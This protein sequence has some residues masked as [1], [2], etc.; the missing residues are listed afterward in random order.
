M[1]VLIID[2][3][4]P[5]AD[6]L[7]RFLE[8]AGVKVDMVVKPRYAEAAKEACSVLRGIQKEEDAYTALVLDIN[9]KDHFI[10]GIMVYTKILTEG[11]RGKFRHLII[12]TKYYP[13]GGTGTN[14]AFK[15]VQ[16][17]RELSFVP[18]L[19]VLPKTTDDHGKILDRIRELANENNTPIGTYGMWKFH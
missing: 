18:A 5:T 16:I 17:F 9:Y 1:R 15:A 8:A 11:L 19:N 6:G 10:G 2:D 7:K 13:S 3:E 12:W 4:V 14:D